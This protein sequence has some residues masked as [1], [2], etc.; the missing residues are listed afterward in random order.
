MRR[1]LECIPAATAWLTLV[2][3]VVAS[4]QLPSVVVVFI[5]L[6]DLYWL[7]KVLYLFSHLVVSF[8]ALR[9][10]MRTDWVARL[11]A[12]QEGRW[13]TVRHLVIFPFY[14]ESREVIRASLRALVA[15]NYPRERLLVVLAGEERGGTED[16][17]VA[18]AIQAEFGNEFGGFLTTVHPGEIPGELPGKGSNETWAARTA[19]RELIDARGIPHDTVL[20]S[21]FDMDTR[22]APEYFGIL[23]FRFLTAAHPLRSSY[24]PTPIFSNNFH[25]VPVFARLIGLSATFWQLM[26]QGRPEQLVTFSSHSMPLPALVA[27][28][29]WDSTI[30]SEDSRIFF[31]CLLRY[32]GDWRSVPLI[33]P[34]YMDAV[35]GRSFLGAMRN[36]YKQQRRWAWGVENFPYLIEALSRTPGIPVRVRWFWLWRTFDGFYSW[37]TSSFI[38]FLFGVLPNVLGGD[39]FR[40]T[41]IS[42]NL[43]RITG[44]LVNLSSVGIITSAFLSLFIIPAYR[45]KGRHW[46]WSL[47]ALL[48]WVLMPLTFIVFGS[49]PA[50]EAQTRLALGGR[51][52]LG[53][54]KTPKALVE[55]S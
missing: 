48:Q 31:Q 9:R 42:Y 17:A 45:E 35:A 54:W 8:H 51:F 38:I 37:A 14:R 40:T 47:W 30:V 25:T 55:R 26:Q 24:Q 32:R 21:V 19:V 43:P 23:T 5:V 1:V 12:E 39:L 15:A 50:L 16:M 44:W 27:V 10:N 46:T 3:L 22:V 11:R 2:F 29:Y 4:W 36:L 6:Y 18:V 28:G 52:R 33:Y 53:F 49:I 34:V 13:E 7:F 20:V 41:V